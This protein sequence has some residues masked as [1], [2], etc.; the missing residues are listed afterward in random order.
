MPG[1]TRRQLCAGTALAGA[2][3]GLAGCD[4]DGG[5]QQTLTG[6]SDLLGTEFEIDGGAELGQTLRLTAI[7]PRHPPVRSPR[8]LGESFTLEF[9]A[10][11]RMTAAQGT[12]FL[13]HPALG[14]FQIFLVPRRP[15]AGADKARF[16]ATYC[17]V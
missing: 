16:A 17:R 2:A 5:Q 3:W 8:P 4:P 11:G 13:T 1:L 7:Q 9:E 15:A 10:A 12:R 14:S 6:F